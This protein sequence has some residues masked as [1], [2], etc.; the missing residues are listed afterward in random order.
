[1]F[2]YLI[3]VFVFC[4]KNLENCYKNVTR[5]NYLL[6]KTSNKKRWLYK[7]DECWKEITR[8]L[9][10]FLQNNNKKKSLVLQLH[11]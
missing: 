9:L 1:M 10:F 3:F 2:L 5:L 11:H 6:Y 4:Y 8:F 7:I